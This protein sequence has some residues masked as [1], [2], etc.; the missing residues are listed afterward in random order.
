MDFTEGYQPAKF[1]I[2]QLF[3][4]SFTEVFIRHPQNTIMMSFHNILLSKL[5]IFYNFI[6]AIITLSNFIG[7][8]C[9]SQILQG[10]CKTPPSD[11]H[12]LKKPSPYRDK[13]IRKEPLGLFNGKKAWP[14]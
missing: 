14:E 8:G 6:E 11:L 1:Q 13:G 4:S 7:L 9:L 3:E 5:H 12:A 2:L 10:G